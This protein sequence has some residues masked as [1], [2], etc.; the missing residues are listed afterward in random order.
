M[1]DIAQTLIIGVSN[2]LIVAL[3]ALGFTLVFAIL[4]LINFAHGDVFMIGSMVGLAAITGLGVARM[5]GPEQAVILVGILFFTMAMTAA[6]NAAIEFF[7]YRPLRRAPKLQ[8]LIAAIG[9][10]FVLENVAILW[11]GPYTVGIDPIFSDSNL[12]AGI[13]ITAVT[14]TL[15][16]VI[17]VAVTIPIML[18]LGVLITRSKLGLAMRATAQDLE[19]AAVMGIDVNRTI[20]LAFVIGGALAGAAGVVQIVYNNTTV[21][22]LGFRFGLNAFTAAVLGGVGNVR[23]AVLGGILVGVFNAIS[24]RYISTAWTNALVFGA[25]VAILV[26]RPTGLLGQQVPDRV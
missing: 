21:W 23:G 18:G 14:I 6:L 15:R 8:P 3:V 2:G 7:A 22:I 12:L 26:L 20:S 11:Y 1:A 25:L 4:E 19:M 13:G 10:S 5:S 17:V 24:D 16:Q 9:V